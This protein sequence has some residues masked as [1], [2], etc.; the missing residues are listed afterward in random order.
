MQSYETVRPFQ[1]SHPQCCRLLPKV[2]SKKSNFLAM[3]HGDSQR[4]LQK[5]GLNVHIRFIGFNRIYRAPACILQY[6]NTNN[7]YLSNPLPNSQVDD[8]PRCFTSRHVCGNDSVN[9][10]FGGN[11]NSKAQAEKHQTSTSKFSPKL[12]KWSKKRKSYGSFM[13]LQNSLGFS[14][15]FVFSNSHQAVDP[16]PPKLLTP[17]PVLDMRSSSS[18]S[19]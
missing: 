10:K 5:V 3:Q 18:C 4:N 15:L 14:L 7:I 11:S 9:E 6:H 8:C 16:R 1:A 17:P 19:R 13:T 2:W 12:Q